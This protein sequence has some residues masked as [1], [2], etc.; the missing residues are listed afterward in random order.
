MAG[1]SFGGIQLEESQEA[2]SPPPSPSGIGGLSVARKCVFFAKLHI[3]F[4]KIVQR[5]AILASFL[6]QLASPPSGAF[7]DTPR[8][9]S[10]VATVPLERSHKR[11]VCSKK[12]FLISS[13]TLEIKMS[14][15]TAA[16]DGNLKN[17]VDAWALLGGRMVRHRPPHPR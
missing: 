5:R 11:L 2:S 15:E 17:S 13:E 16:A 12:K 8:N 9:S 4:D 14:I 7:V 1:L 10:I 3:V 6:F